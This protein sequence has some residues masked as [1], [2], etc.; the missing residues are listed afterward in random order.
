MAYSEKLAK[1]DRDRLAEFL[2]SVE[3]AVS[4]IRNI[5]GTQIRPL[6][7]AEVKQHLF[8][9]VN[10]FH[11]DEGLRDIQCSDMIRIGQKKG[12]SLPFVMKRYLPDRMKVYVTD[13][14]LQEA[15]SQ[16]YMSMLERIGVHALFPCGK[17]DME[18]RRGKLPGGTG[19]EGELFGRYREFDKAIKSRM[20]A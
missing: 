11:D 1:A 6:N 19:R 4:I 3:S 20:T 7:V 15:N 18:I 9:Y 2:E 8:R 16:L 12:Y 17:P 5:R 10:G 14:T 13:S